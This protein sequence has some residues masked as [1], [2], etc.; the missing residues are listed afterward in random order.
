MDM[1]VNVPKVDLNGNILN[2][3]IDINNKNLNLPGIDINGNVPNLGL[4]GEFGANLPNVEINNNNKMNIPSGEVNLEGQIPNIN[5]NGNI[6]NKDIKIPKIDAKIESPNIKDINIPG[7]GINKKDININKKNINIEG[8][9]GEIKNSTGSFNMFGEIEGKGIKIDKP[10]IKLNKDNEYYISGIIPGGDTNNINIKGS[11]R[12]LYD[13]NI[14]Q[15]EVNIKSSKLRFN[16]PDMNIKGSRRLD[17]QAPQLN[18]NIKGSR[19]IYDTQINTNTQNIPEISV[20]SPKIELK[21][22]NKNIKLDKPE[23]NIKEEGELIFSGVIPGKKELS[24]NIKLSANA[25]KVEIKA[26]MDKPNIQNKV[27]METDIN[28]SLKNGIN[29]EAKKFNILPDQNID[30]QVESKNVKNSL[31]GSNNNIDIEMPKFNIEVNN[32]EK[33]QELNIEENN[34]NIE[35]EMPKVEIN[36]DAQEQGQDNNL[37]NININNQESKVY[38]KKGIRGLPKVGLK[39][40]DFVSSKIDV[41]GKLDVNNIDTSNLKPADAGANGTKIG[42]RIIE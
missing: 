33:N 30:I 27:K 37:F 39:K 12:M 3:S 28:P 16:Q 38:A 7:L 35:I 32:E 14:N 15:P 31:K 9:L 2:P 25:P 4:N 17:F 8:G 1:N 23:I 19:M 11:R 18:D 20:N 34:N 24:K 10:N 29:I 41:G 6:E 22:G 40:T 21:S 5:L 36:L 42:N 26:D 13:Y